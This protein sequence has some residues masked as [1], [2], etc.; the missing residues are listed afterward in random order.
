MVKFKFIIEFQTGAGE[1]VHSVGTFPI[2]SKLFAAEAVL[3]CTR[4]VGGQVRA[5]LIGRPE[6]LNAV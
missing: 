4:Q 5:R 3:V 1:A 6:L 2:V